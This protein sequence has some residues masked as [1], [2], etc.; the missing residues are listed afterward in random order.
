M[1]L[2]MSMLPPINCTLRIL[3]YTKRNA[4]DINSCCLAW[5]L[6]F[7][8]VGDLL[9]PFEILLRFCIPFRIDAQELHLTGF[10]LNLTFVSC[11]I[12]L[13]LSLHHHSISFFHQCPFLLW[14]HTC[15]TTLTLVAYFIWT[16]NSI[17][18][19]DNGQMCP[20]SNLLMLVPSLISY[21]MVTGLAGIRIF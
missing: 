13:C 4:A 2:L 7:F 9:F 14:T 5:I 18:Y 21:D 16:V 8:I 15:S 3:N 10:L 6:D 20:I 1:I 19:P 17:T 12:C 11:G